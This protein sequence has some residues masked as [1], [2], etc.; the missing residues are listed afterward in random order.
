MAT[1]EPSKT[2]TWAVFFVCLFAIVVTIP[3]YFPNHLGTPVAFL[4]VTSIS[5]IGLYIAYTI[6]VFLRWRTGERFVAGTWTLGRKYKWINP[7]AVVWVASMRDHL[8]PA[9]Q[10]RRGSVGKG[11]NWSAV[12]YAPIVTIGVILAVTIWYAVSAKK[13]FK[14]PIRTIDELDSR[15][16]TSQA[17]G[18]LGARRR[19]GGWA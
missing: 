18:R 9:V 4:A 16:P 6:P 11:F 15:L 2:P 17:P 10:P 14:G 1:L 5:V 7:I 13:T 8:L 3:A 19:E 12:N